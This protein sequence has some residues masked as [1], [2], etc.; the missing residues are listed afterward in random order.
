MNSHKIAILTDSCADLPP[1]LLKKYSIYVV[2]LKIRFSDGEYLDCVTIQPKQVYERLPY[3]LPKTSLPDGALVEDTL[4]RI[5]QAGYEKV[6]AIHLSGGLSGTCNMVRVIGRQFVGLEVVAFDTL[7]GALGEGLTVLQAARMLERGFGWSEMLHAVPQL[8]AGTKVFFCV[9]TL[10]Y[11][12]KGGRIGK[13]TAVA[14]TL[15]NIKPII[16]FA[17]TGEL[18]SVA[19]V[20]GRRQAM[21]KMAEM[22]REQYPDEGRYALGV[23]HGGCPGEMKELRMLAEALLPDAVSTTEGEVDC[24]LGVY[25]G[26]NLLGVGI[27][28]LPDAFFAD[29]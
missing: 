10:E 14:G 28:L 25:V 20:R 19:K 22:V 1:H 24:T 16:T 15:L 23:E 6:L 29:T 12:Q 5:R 18:V 17:P 3:E 4:R 11:L 26:P 13:I 21:L 7:S 27:Q 2:P 9:D 8:I